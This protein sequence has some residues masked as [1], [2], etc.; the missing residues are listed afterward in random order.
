MS[1]KD[2]K[3]AKRQ[4]ELEIQ[5]KEKFVPCSLLL[6]DFLIIYFTSLGALCALA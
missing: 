2:A 5:T 4:I 1:R 3:T 6:L